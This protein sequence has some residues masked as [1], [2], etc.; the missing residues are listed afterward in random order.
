MTNTK[1]V[2]RRQ[3][4][5][6]F[7]EFT[8]PREIPNIIVIKFCQLSLEILLFIASCEKIRPYCLRISNKE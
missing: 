6:I 8:I 7:L 3:P 4:G 5:R 1:S 2:R